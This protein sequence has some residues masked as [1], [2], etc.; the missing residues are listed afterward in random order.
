MKMEK[1]L[2]EGRGAV[3]TTVTFLAGFGRLTL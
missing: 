3:Y 1:S 2:L